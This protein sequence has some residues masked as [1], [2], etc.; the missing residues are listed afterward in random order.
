[1][2]DHIDRKE[3][4]GFTGDTVEDSEE[5]YYDM[6][7]RL[8]KAEGFHNQH[9][10]LMHAAIGISGEVG[11]L[12]EAMGFV[13]DGSGYNKTHIVEE[14]GDIRFYL[15]AFFNICV[16]SQEYDVEGLKSDPVNFSPGNNRSILLRLSVESSGVL[17][18]VKKGWVYGKDIDLL[19]TLNGLYII[20]YLI[21]TLAYRLEI[22]TNET[23]RANIIKLTGK[24]GR[25]ENG[26]TDQAA[27]VRADKV[28]EK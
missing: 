4:G 8:F 15:C 7:T 24:G 23:L 3:G 12:I 14:L 27:Q 5:L 28:D 16:D 21:D 20:T 25:Y 18:N 13:E 26:Y 1:M 19:K 22:S 11:E 10:A 6:V 2:T 9:D 17:D